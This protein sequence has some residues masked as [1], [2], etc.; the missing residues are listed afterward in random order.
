MSVKIKYFYFFR[1][2]TPK[3]DSCISTKWEPINELN[4]ARLII[5][6]NI[7]M[8]Y[9]IYPERTKFYEEVYRKFNVQK[10]KS[11]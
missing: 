5:D 6:K 4:P 3:T 1:N 2:P 10:S 7:S 11:L 9:S 8:E